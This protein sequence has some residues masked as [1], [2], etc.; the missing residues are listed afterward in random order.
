ME[1]KKTLIAS[2]KRKAADQQL[3]STQNILTET[4]ASSTPDLNVNLLKLESLTRAAQRSRSK[5]SGS[6]HPEAPSSTDFV[7]PPTCHLSHRDEEYFRA[8]KEQQV[9]TDY[10]LDRLALV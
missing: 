1:E 7:L 5:S 4:L 10:H 3:Y 6:N 9:T 8:I 2:L